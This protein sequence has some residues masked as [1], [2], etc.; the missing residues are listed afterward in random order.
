MALIESRARQMMES[1]AITDLHQGMDGITSQLTSY[2]TRFEAMPSVEDMLAQLP[3]GVRELVNQIRLKD[4][5]GFGYV[6]MCD[7]RDGWILD[8]ALDMAMA[9]MRAASFPLRVERMQRSL[10]QMT[11]RVMG[12][13]ADDGAGQGRPDLVHRHHWAMWARFPE[14]MRAATGADDV[15]TAVS[16]ALARYR[17][18]VVMP[19][20]EATATAEDPEVP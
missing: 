14:V 6:A 16:E 4:S 18:A 11:V 8:N 13:G 15:D 3:E 17:A 2:R 19:T 7:R 5:L 9:D 1:N 10:V 20:E 12:M